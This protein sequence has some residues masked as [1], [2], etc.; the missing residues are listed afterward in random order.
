MIGWIILGIVVI[1][2]LFLMV[3]YNNLG[4]PAPED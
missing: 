1:F 4:D 2:A 3:L